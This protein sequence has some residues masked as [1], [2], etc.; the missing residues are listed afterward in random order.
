MEMRTKYKPGLKSYVKLF[1]LSFV[2]S[3]STQTSVNAT[4][5]ENVD[6]IVHGRYV[7]T[8]ETENLVIEN[9]AVAIDNGVIIAVGPGGDITGKYQAKK[10]ISGQDRVLLPG[11]SV[12][13]M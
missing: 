11:Q 10:V 8:M 4:A 2:M 1:V 3:M 12:L 5:K 13:S 7:V 9:G 6:L